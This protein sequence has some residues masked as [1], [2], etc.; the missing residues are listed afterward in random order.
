MTTTKASFRLPVKFRHQKL[1]KELTVHRF[2]LRETISACCRLPLVLFFGIAAGSRCAE[3]AQAATTD[4]A[5]TDGDTPVDE[6]AKQQAVAAKD[7]PFA[8]LS[9]RW[10]EVIDHDDPVADIGVCSREAAA[11][12]VRRQPVEQKSCEA[13]ADLF[14]VSGNGVGT[15]CGVVVCMMF[16]TGTNDDMRKWGLLADMRKDCDC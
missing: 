4:R 6:A 10:T 8:R 16:I 7:A 3:P 9:G 11:L 2:A 5:E 14:F 12:L 13:L 15:G 1:L